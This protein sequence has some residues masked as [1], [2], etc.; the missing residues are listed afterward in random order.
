MTLSWKPKRLMQLHHGN[1]QGRRIFIIKK[2]QGWCNFIMERSI[3]CSLPIKYWDI[4]YKRLKENIK[5]LPGLN[6]SIGPIARDCPKWPSGNGICVRSCLPNLCGWTFGQ[7][8]FLC[9]ASAHCPLIMVL[10]NDFSIEQHLCQFCPW[11][12]IHCV[13]FIVDFR[14]SSSYWSL[15]GNIDDEVLIALQNLKCYEERYHYTVPRYH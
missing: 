1:K 13:Q 8:F 14:S 3:F 10:Q 2:T 9:Q 7:P 11:S 4:C 15:F 12:H 5:A 6:N